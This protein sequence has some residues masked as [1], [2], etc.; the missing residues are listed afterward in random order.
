MN[1]GSRLNLQEQEKK[2]NYTFI[3][4]MGAGKHPMK[5]IKFFWKEMF[6]KTFLLFLGIFQ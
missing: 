4:L 1:P 3:D 6:S 2:Q 5:L